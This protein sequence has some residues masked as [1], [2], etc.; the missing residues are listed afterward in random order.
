MPRSPDR[1]LPLPLNRRYATL[2]GYG[3]FP[4]LKR[5]AKLKSRYAAADCHF[6]KLV[7]SD[8]TVRL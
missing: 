2:E 1:W 6:K 4:A 3:S 8:R 5:R 7:K